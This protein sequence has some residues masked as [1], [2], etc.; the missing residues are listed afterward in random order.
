MSVQLEWI[1]DDRVVA[2]SS[3]TVIVNIS[4]EAAA[5]DVRKG[6]LLTLVVERGKVRVSAAGVSMADAMIGDVIRATVSNSHRVV[7]ARLT[8]KDHAKV[9]E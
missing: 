1:T 9:M 6:A 4:E 7:R 2:S 3:A 8:S 5:P